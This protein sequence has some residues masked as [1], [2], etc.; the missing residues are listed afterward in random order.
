MCSVFL[1]KIVGSSLPVQIIGTFRVGSRIHSTI[2]FWAC[3]SE[4]ST[5]SKITH[6]LRVV[7][8]RINECIFTAD[9]QASLIFSTSSKL[10]IDLEAFISSGSNPYVLAAAK[11]SVVFP[12]P[13]GPDNIIDFRK[14]PDS[15]YFLRDSFSSR[16]PM[17]SS[18]IVGRYASEYITCLF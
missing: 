4:P 2:L 10:R 6:V 11:A 9:R 13:G 14:V 7:S 18:N 17:T 5:S 3:G 12:I 16:Y 15:R 8:P 1:L